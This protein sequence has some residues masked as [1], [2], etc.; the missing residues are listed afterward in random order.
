MEP[1]QA[2]GR[3]LAVLGAGAC[4]RDGAVEATARWKRW[5]VVSRGRQWRGLGIVVPSE[6]VASACP[7]RSTPTTGPLWV[8]TACA[9]STWTDP[10]P[11][12]RP[13]PGLLGNG[14]CEH[15]D[16]RYG[17]GTTRVQAYA[18]QTG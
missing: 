5:R 15:L 3:L 16:A 4:P 8:G 12:H 6:R 10:D 11:C 13:V 2:P 1:P 9:C 14:R 7:P 18:A 17:P